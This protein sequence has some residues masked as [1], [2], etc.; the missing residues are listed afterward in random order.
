[1]TL[2]G[3]EVAEKQKRQRKAEAELKDYSVTFPQRCLKMALGLPPFIPH[4]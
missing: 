1:M 3:K 2:L 4:I